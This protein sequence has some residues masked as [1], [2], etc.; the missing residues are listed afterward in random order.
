MTDKSLMTFKAAV[1]QWRKAKRYRG[2]R[3]P[4]SLAV[5]AKALALKHGI[6]PVAKAT[7]LGYDQLG[8]KYDRGTKSK[9]KATSDLG[10]RRPQLPSF[11]RL[12]LRS[13]QEPL[14]EVETGHGVKLR[15]F[16]LT[17]ETLGLM[18]SICNEERE[19]P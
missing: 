7:G 12:E 16:A 14:L 2:E 1:D 17:P 15:V 13:P 10:R 9:V 3:L 4:K 6:G 5:K 8:R 11:S 19:E 18:Q